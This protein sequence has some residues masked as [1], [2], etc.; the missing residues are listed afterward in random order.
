MPTSADRA[1]G[2]SLAYPEA[3]MLKNPS[4]SK[5]EGEVDDKYQY[6]S[7]T[8]DDSLHGWISLIQGIGFW[9]ITPSHEFRTAGPLKQDLTCH[10]GPTCLS[11]CLLLTFTN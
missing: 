11:V 4:N 2:Q 1:R 6:S 3:V 5:F 9:I 7:E 8:K 10:V